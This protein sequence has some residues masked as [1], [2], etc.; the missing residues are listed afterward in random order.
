MKEPINLVNP[1]MYHSGDIEIIAHIRG[2]NEFYKLSPALSH[3]TWSGDIKSPSR[4]L[5]FEFL[6]GV[7]DER[8]RE[9]GLVVGSTVCMY[10][11]DK[12]L[13]RGTVTDISRDT[14]NNELKVT[15]HD[16]GYILG[17]DD[18]SFNFVNTTACDIAKAVLKGSK[19]QMQLTYG[20]LAVAGTKITKMFVGVSRYDAIMSAYTAHS[21]ADKSHKKYM[22]EV[23]LDKINVIEKG[24]VKLKIMFEE[25]VNIE[26]ANYKES[27][28]NMVNSVLVVDEKGNIIKQKTSKDFGKVFKIVTK[29]IEQ[30]KDKTVT[31]D[32]INKE[33][34]S[35]ERTCNLSG[36]GNT[37]CK[38][39]YKVQV[40]D[41]HT[42][43]VGEFYIDKDKHT[44][45]G[46]VYNIDLDLNFDN[47]MDEKDAG[48]DEQKETSTSNS[49]STMGTD[50]GHGITADMINKVLKGK[51]A[52]RGAEY[53]KWGNAYKVNPLLIALI[54]RK[55]TG[56]NFNSRLARECNNFGGITGDPMYKKKSGRFVI[57][58]SVEV[59]VERHFR[60]VSVKYLHDWKK[61]SIDAIM[62]IYAPPSDGNDTSGY[63]AE[64]KSWYQQFSGRAWSNSLLGTGVANE[65]EAHN[66][67]TVYSSTNSGNGSLSWNGIQFENP[68]QMRIVQFAYSMIGKGR[69][70]W[71]GHGSPY[72]S[73]CS[74]FVHFC[75]ASA[76]INIGWT[77]ADQRYNGRQIPLNQIKPG[78]FVVMSS[79]ASGSGRHVVLYVGNGQI[80]HNGGPSGAPI[81][82][83]S[84]YTTGWYTVRRCW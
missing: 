9:I 34:K 71:G 45:S 78:D 1:D 22:I 38:A 23:D 83:R 79:A 50:W 21:K 49:V 72:R 11:D 61:R 63:I 12:E 2:K 69:Y 41:N 64:M 18:V 4:T 17:K 65:Q 36:Y 7:A 67:I 20:K 48:K 46:G 55:E 54:Q 44:W 68:R 81:T 3:I 25:M 82:K 8:V 39:G 33:F 27:I 56:T 14:N 53:I 6:K 42:G 15:A 19:G 70:T 10:E 37:S 59:G 43:L 13:F 58:P 30:R 75:Y 40:K 76:G 57:Y 26:S 28:E 51:L 5:E 62:A 73:D 60:L 74:G 52:G 29:V 47:I 84:L 77:T 16:I 80:I 32:E 35:V 31:D 66:N 24:I